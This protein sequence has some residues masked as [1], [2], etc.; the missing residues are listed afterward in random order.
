MKNTIDFFACYDE[1]IDFES[2]VDE[3]K[4]N[5]RLLK[6]VFCIEINNQILNIKN[7][8]KEYGD[9]WDEITTTVAFFSCY[10]ITR[11]TASIYELHGK[12]IADIWQKNLMKRMAR[13]NL[14]GKNMKSFADYD[15]LTES[16][17][18]V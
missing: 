14:L 9:F 2:P 16:E 1:I 10:H 13:E 18:G 4:I 12:E 5:N 15:K 3:I 11:I 8:K 6:K 17:F 7:L